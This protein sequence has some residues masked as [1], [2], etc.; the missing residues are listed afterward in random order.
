MLSHHFE[1]AAEEMGLGCEV[2]RLD[3][4]QRE[5]IRDIHDRGILWD[6]SEESW[7]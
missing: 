5:A 3:L 6:V 7:I 4:I 1:I 2:V